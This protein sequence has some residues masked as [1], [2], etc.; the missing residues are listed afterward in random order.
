MLLKLKYS[1]KLIQLKSSTTDEAKAADD[2][3]VVD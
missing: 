1:M 2:A 3:E